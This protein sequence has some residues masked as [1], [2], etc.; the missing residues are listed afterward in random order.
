LALL[1][2][3]AARLYQV[4]PPPLARRLSRRYIAGQTVKEAVD[5]ASRLKAHGLLATVDILG[6][7][8][9]TAAGASR[10]AQRYLETLAAL[11]EAELQV[12][13][14]VKPSALG[15]LLDWQLC[16]EHM[17]AIA[18]AAKLGEGFVCVDMEASDAVPGTLALYRRLRS[19]GLDNVGVVIQARLHRARNDIVDLAVVRPN[20]RVCKGIYV[21]PASIA[22]G[23]R[24]AIRRN[25]VFC[26][27]TLL[28][29]RGFAAIATHDEALVVAA[30]ERLVAHNRGTDSYEFQMLLGVR[31]D[32]AES[33]ASA[34]HP[35]RVYVP[36]GE[37]SQQYASRRLRENPEFAAHVVRAYVG[38]FSGKLPAAPL[39]RTSETCE[40]ADVL[41]E[42]GERA[43]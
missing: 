22:Y 43:R 5:V 17:A 34:G 40:R 23:D 39:K 11:R 15:S 31:D 9:T 1:G 30:L 27:D 10:F 28:R 24:E 36:F 3:L 26:L 37:E 29:S 8:V 4:T 19:R 16:E 2:S 13:V 33:L 32:L 38:A 6:E 18:E 20:V 42:G 35:V 41:L 12:H 7:G 21:E 14:S 25:Y